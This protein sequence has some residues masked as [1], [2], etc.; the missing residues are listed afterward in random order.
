MIEPRGADVLGQRLARVGARIDPALTDGDVERLIE[1]ARQLRRRRAVARVGLAAAAACAVA[2]ALVGGLRRGGAPPSAGMAEGGVPGVGTATS[3]SLGV[4]RLADGSVVTPL[5]AQSRLVVSEDTPERVSIALAQGGGHF[6]V[7]PR[8][9]RLFSVIAGE[10]E[11]TVVG[12]AFKV[13]R[14]AEQV[15]VTVERG[16][17]R[18]AWPGGSETLYPGQSKWFPPPVTEPVNRAAAPSRHVTLAERDRPRTLPRAPVVVARAERSA[19][20]APADAG[21]DESADDLLAAADAART[22]GRPEE[23]ATLLR[24]LLKQHGDD[25]RAPLAAFTLGRVLL[26]EL[27]RPREAATMFA[28]VRARAP[29]GPF[30]ED[31]LAREVEA[32]SK[33]SEPERARALAQEYLRLYPHGSRARA[34]KV[35]GG[36]E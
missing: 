8:P 7:V 9:H 27:A 20:A 24:R 28:D 13:E 34:V 17:V 30:A 6:D 1:G 21:R 26:M 2:L 19:E 35:L 15:G 25:P 3:G 33:A 10:V 23:G 11:V 31:A 12:T 18:V 16:A 14:I 29:E 5:D 4:L 36:L 22:A 32:W